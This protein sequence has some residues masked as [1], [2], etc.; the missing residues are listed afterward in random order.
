M[1]GRS[2]GWSRKCAPWFAWGWIAAAAVLATGCSGWEPME[3]P[4]R[5]YPKGPGAF[6]KED[7]EFVIYRR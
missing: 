2:V 4:D 6:S 7:G 3:V 5:E 1:Q